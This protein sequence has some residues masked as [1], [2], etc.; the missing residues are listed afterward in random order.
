MLLQIQL[1]TVHLGSMGRFI[2]RCYK[3]ILPIHVVGQRE[4][5]LTFAEGESYFCSNKLTAHC[6]HSSSLL[7]AWG[8]P[9]FTGCV[10]SKHTESLSAPIQGPKANCHFRC[11]IWSPQLVCTTRIILG[12]PLKLLMVSSD[13]YKWSRKFSF[14]SFNIFHYS[15]YL[16]STLENC[17]LEYLFQ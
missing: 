13:F 8:H 9:F 11:R 14:Y 17:D 12:V 1:G 15:V 7:F 16:V 3:F 4:M 5:N 10:I 6:L 2:L